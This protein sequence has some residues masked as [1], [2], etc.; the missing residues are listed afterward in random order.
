MGNH[1]VSRDLHCVLGGLLGDPMSQH[2]RKAHKE[3]RLSRS[4][5]HSVYSPWHDKLEVVRLHAI[6]ERAAFEAK[7]PEG[8]ELVVRRGNR[9]RAF[10]LPKYGE[11][12]VNS[13]GQVETAAYTWERHAFGHGPRWIVRKIKP[14][15]R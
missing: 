11:M 5:A 10:R 6:S 1:H 12:F 4:F 14:C 3:R 15:T 13:D 9:K 7:V 8:Y 2:A